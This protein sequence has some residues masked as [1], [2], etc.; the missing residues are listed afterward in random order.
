MAVFY[1]SFCHLD[2]TSKNIYVS[3]DGK[4]E[5][6]CGFS[7]SPCASIKYAIAHRSTQGDHVMIDGRKGKERGSFEEFGIRLESKITIEGFNGK[8]IIDCKMSSIVFKVT[9][10]MGIFKN[11]EFKFLQ[12]DSVLESKK[13]YLETTIAILSS[14]SSINIENCQ[15]Q[16]VP[17]A[18]IS[19]CPGICT[20]IVKD[21]NFESQYRAI[22]VENLGGCSFYTNLFIRNKFIGRPHFTVEALK[23]HGGISNKL[24]N[25]NISI[26]SCLFAHFGSASFIAVRGKLRFRIQNSEFHNN[27]MVDKNA[28]LSSAF[29]IKIYNVILG[30]EAQRII[31]LNCT[32][33]NN[34]SYFGGAIMLQMYAAV[35]ASLEI[36]NSTFLSN[37]A[38]HSGGAIF[39]M[40]SLKIDLK[41]S[42]FYNN[43]CGYQ[44]YR[45]KV[46][47]AAVSPIHGL[48]GALHIAYGVSSE[49]WKAPVANISNCVFKNNSAEHDGGSVYF[50]GK[51]MK[52][53]NVYMES[54]GY[55]RGR[56]V[57]P[58][59]I[60]S[61]C[62]GDFRNV[63]IRVLT[64]TNRQ[65]AAN[66]LQGTA[67]PVSIDEQSKFICSQGSILH[68]KSWTLTQ[69]QKLYMK[70]LRMFS[71]YCVQCPPDFYS[72]DESTFQ[73]RT[74]TGGTCMRCSSGGRCRSG[75]IKAKNNFWG[76]KNKNA[77]RINFIQ[78][79]AG[80]GCFGKECV[81]YDVCAP[82]RKGK[83][84]GMC[85]DGYSE[86]FISSKCISNQ[87]CQRVKFWL[88]AVISFALF[89]IFI[90][91]KQEIT[92]FVRSQIRIIIRRKQQQQQ[93]YEG[94]NDRYVAL[95]SD[96]DYISTDPY[97]H[98]SAQFEE[99]DNMPV[100]RH[101]EN[102]SDIVTGIIKILSYFYQIEFILRAYSNDVG[103]HIF[104]GFRHFASIFFNFQFSIGH[105]SSS[106]CALFNMTPVWKLILKTSFVAVALV[107]LLV[108]LIVTKIYQGIKY[109]FRRR[110]D[111][112][113]LVV[114]RGKT[115]SDRL[116]QAI[117]EIML[118]SYAV[119]TKSIF[120]LL[121]CV[122]VGGK[123]VLFIQGCIQCYEP[124]QYVLM[125]I[126][127]CW[128]IPFCL[129][130]M[131]L[132]SLLQERKISKKGV[133]FGVS[134]PLLCLLQILLVRCLKKGRE[135][136]QNP[137]H[138]HHFMDSILKLISGPFKNKGKCQIRWE[139]IYLLRRLVIVSVNS[140]VQDQIYKLYS[141]LLI[142]VLFL[143]HHVNMKPFKNKLLN[144]VETISLTALI[145]LNCV[146][147]FA[148][149]DA[150]HGLHEEG[151]DLL[152][153]KTFAW[154]ELVLVL[155]A[156]VVT[157]LIVGLLII[158]RTA[159]SIAK[160]LSYLYHLVV[161][162]VI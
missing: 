53:L 28:D 22:L 27:H 58:N 109:T 120:S 91:Y 92:Q 154:I 128:V 125:G 155:F 29:G 98:T 21:S 30:D 144:M 82:H 73:N 106:T 66:L 146:K 67:P 118:L 101:E 124:W 32:F 140:F 89:L 142:Q 139:G 2:V 150:K 48:G 19:S 86:S 23:F 153:L 16:G 105:D 116:W 117:F 87:E 137:V 74:M 15:F 10:S 24:Q 162:R 123:Q 104:Q 156:P 161:G 25:W 112:N 64:P 127:L 85:A 50:T 40:G 79:P 159:I 57:F 77:N 8:P 71:F 126:G 113:P 76:Y 54:P 13:Y 122:E 72:F 47:W 43:F 63:K 33:F 1:I 96:E 20:N 44:P 80:Y 107:V 75:V 145:M 46:M 121:T 65:D 52:I 45:K 132:P 141:L 68:Q 147:T 115:F 69:D 35:A 49:C 131:L 94:H 110:S 26:D 3:L 78:L 148:V 12:S 31:V 95:L 119:I 151:D 102:D 18:L 70:V 38:V 143:L 5:E 111:S 158:A 17:I 11:L 157:G 34:T 9:N 37:T 60:S 41:N 7:T 61:K 100:D 160:L 133:F 134:F 138:H 55:G 130:V 93:Q 14:N 103:S 39:L 62:G 149:Y 114:K 152:L 99:N 88:I 56:K 90:L 4:D 135:D 97:L 42:E 108:L 84:C 83:L 129:F 136:Q 81:T 59:V 6:W 36:I 51:Q